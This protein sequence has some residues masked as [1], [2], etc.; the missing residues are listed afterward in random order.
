M[1]NEHEI[2]HDDLVP[3]PRDEG[4]ESTHL[5]LIINATTFWRDLE[6]IRWRFNN[7]PEIQNIIETGITLLRYEIVMAAR[8]QLR[9]VKRNEPIRT[10][11]IL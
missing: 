8:T 4:T 9:K 6:N 10:N 7:Q 1:T 3:T 11:D 5:D 2:G